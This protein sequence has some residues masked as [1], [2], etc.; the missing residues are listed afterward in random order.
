MPV[1]ED[2]IWGLAAT[3]GAMS[4]VHMDDCGLATVVCIMTGSK[5]WVVLRG[6]GTQGEMGDLTSTHA[7]PLN[8]NHF[9]TGKGAFEAEALQLRA[10]DVL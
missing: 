9:S 7:F 3:S 5:W 6:K 2:T 10:G 8:W 4:M 1:E